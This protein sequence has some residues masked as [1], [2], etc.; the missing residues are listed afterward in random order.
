MFYSTVAMSFYTYLSHRH[1]F[2]QYMKA[3]RRPS[4]PGAP[5]TMIPQNLAS[6][7]QTALIF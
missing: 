1:L 4:H 7:D 2:R 6:H 3:G 5:L